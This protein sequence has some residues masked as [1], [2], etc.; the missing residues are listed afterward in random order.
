MM[1]S[2]KSERK[3]VDFR[4]LFERAPGLLLLLEPDLTIAA[5]SDA[6]LAATMTTRDAIVGRGIFEIFPDNPGDENASGVS[7]L[8]SSLERVRR[9]RAADSMAVQRYD[10]RRPA[11]EGGGFEERFWSPI[12]T[13]IL[14]E[15]GAIAFI[16]HRAEDVTEFVRLRR[17]DTEQLER[18]EA[19]QT[20][21][22]RV[23]A[24]VYLRAQ[25]VQ[26]ANAELR[27]TNEELAIKERV[28]SELY[29]RLSRLDQLK[30][31]FFANVSHELRTPLALILG[32][33]EKL[34]ADKGLDASTRRD[35]ELIDRSSRIL[36]K[37][38]TDL[39]DVAKLEAGKMPI[40][41]A[42]AD[43]AALAREVVTHFEA[44]AEERHV[45]LSLDTPET[46]YGE[47]DAN[48]VHR[49][50]MNLLSNAFKF[51]PPEGN[52]R[53]MLGDRDGALILTIDDSGPGVPVEQRDA[54][55]DRFFQGEVSSTRR[56][57]GTGLG[58]AIVKDFVE[59]H[60]GSIAVSTSPEGGARFTVSLPRIAPAGTSLR[61]S[62]SMRPAAPTAATAISSASPRAGDGAVVPPEDR[63]DKPLVLVVEDHVDL[64]RFLSESLADDYDVRAVGDGRA[65]LLAALEHKPELSLTDVVMPVM[66]GDAGVRALRQGPEL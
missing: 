27:R 42:H 4:R 28:I 41:Y 56:F 1:G 23:E 35:L 18:N 59:L 30:T 5:A 64:R 62:P 12:N 54:I 39:L 43:V 16:L 53:C 14:G 47:V 13:P 15:D 20:K 25:E 2:S 55:F 66:C 49:I 36:F 31:Q 9:D 33:T 32:P 8:R 52:V 40:E 10:I 38:V 21:A 44:V 11:A 7:N 63:R 50:L 61:A 65:G 46:L 3:A 26:A 45:T 57:G 58:L 48:K 24:E 17:H 51:T 22:E 6:Y 34:L 37:H 19:L 60:R 29:D